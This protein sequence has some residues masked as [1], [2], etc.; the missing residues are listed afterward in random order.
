MSSKDRKITFRGPINIGI[1]DVW[2]E[3]TTQDEKIGHI[4]KNGVFQGSTSVSVGLTASDLQI[5]G[6]R[7]ALV[8]ELMKKLIE[9]V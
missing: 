5:I 1:I 3:G 8:K 4:D 2:T 9:T 7:C 6:A